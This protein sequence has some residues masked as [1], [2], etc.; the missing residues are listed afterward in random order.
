VSKTKHTSK[1]QQK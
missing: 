1:H